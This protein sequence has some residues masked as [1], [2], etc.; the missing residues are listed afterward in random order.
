MFAVKHNGGML[1]IPCGIKN[2]FILF[3]SVKVQLPLP[4]SKSSPAFSAGYHLLLSS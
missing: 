2:L 1:K 3:F 4:L